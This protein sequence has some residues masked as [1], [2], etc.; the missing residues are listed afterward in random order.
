MAPKG[1]LIRILFARGW[2]PLFIDSHCHLDSEEFDADR[3]EVLARARAAGVSQILIPGVNL[4]SSRKAVSLA[5]SNTMLYAAV[6]IHPGETLNIQATDWDAL[7]SLT[8]RPKV[9][10]I[11]EIG[12]DYALESIPPPMQK[13]TLWRQLNLAEQ[14]RLP[15]ILHMREARQTQQASCANDLLDIVRR[16]TNNL[17][18]RAAHDGDERLTRLAQHPGVFHAFSGSLEM[19]QEVIRLGFF[20]GVGGPVTFKN[21]R[22]RQEITAALPLERLL[23]ETDAPVLAPQPYRG[24]R[25]EPAYLPSIAD[26]IALL[27]HRS[28]MEIAAI[29]SEN[30]RRLFA[31]E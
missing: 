27:H 8:R 5:E 26:K 15:V 13:E 1:G 24:R 12:L 11:G 31:L 10:A 17:Q 2:F 28:V 29:T 14:A 23:L 25:N 7:E 18:Q 19:A 22:T 9:V 3:A 20:I 6:G 16:W 30:A 21:A 4:A